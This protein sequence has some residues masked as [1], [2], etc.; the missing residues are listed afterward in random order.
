MN[1][2]I[3]AKSLVV[4]VL[5]SA[6]TMAAEMTVNKSNNVL[7]VS[8]KT[9]G[10]TSPALVK[11]KKPIV[12]IPIKLRPRPVIEH[13]VVKPIKK[14]IFT[15]DTKPT[16]DMRND[17]AAKGLEIRDQ[18]PRG[19]CSVFA[20]TFLIEYMTARKYGTKN[21][22]Y[23]EE[24]LNYASNKAL[25]QFNDGGFFEELDAGFQ[26][27]GIVS[28]SVLPY[29]GAFNPNMTVSA[30]IM[31]QANKAERFTYGVIKPWDNS[32][33]ATDAQI[34]SVIAMLEYRIPVAVG[35][36][37]QK[38][39]K[40]KSI[41]GIEFI[42]TPPKNQMFDGHSVALVGYKKSNLF[43][44]G[45]YFIFRNSWGKG[46]GDQGYGYVT[47]DYVKKYANDLVYY[48]APYIY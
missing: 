35:L 17:I 45:G 29:Q 30:D 14:P 36:W 31:A 40:T 43:P 47:F 11:P 13:M 22:N 42:D 28:E 34:N 15:L 20:M 9:T 3:L 1:K 39:Y 41:L 4:I 24:F 27:Y 48:W 44:G 46:Y 6:C 16:L 26:K 18:R 7:K 19:T 23:S 21:L 8:P 33:G 37:W 38:N 2:S 10:A 5:G 12:M 25:N 32:K